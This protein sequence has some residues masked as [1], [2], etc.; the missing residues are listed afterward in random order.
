VSGDE[1]PED[2]T[3]ALIDAVKDW[4]E[5][6]PPRYPFRQSSAHGEPKPTTTIERTC[7]KC[8]ASFLGLA[9]GKTGEVGIWHQMAWWC[10]VECFGRNPVA[11]R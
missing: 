3:L 9:A 11:A 1:Q 4:A 7:R 5:L 10:S 8:G 2:N 6:T